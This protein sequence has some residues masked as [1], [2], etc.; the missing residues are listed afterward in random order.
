MPRVTEHPRLIILRTGR[1]SEAGVFLH[2]CRIQQP[3]PLLQI[4][5]LPHVVS[6][7]PIVTLYVAFKASFSQTIFIL[8]TC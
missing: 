7:P 1:A 3:L 8:P 6:D 5:C 2:V 4:R